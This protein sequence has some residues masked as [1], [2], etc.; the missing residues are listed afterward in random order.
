M[1]RQA[2]EPLR[3]SLEKLK[4]INIPE[5]SPYK[6]ISYSWGEVPGT[7][8]IECDGASLETTRSVHDVLRRL[9]DAEKTKRVWIDGLCINQRDVAE[10]QKVVKRMRDIYASAS[11]VIIWLG[12]SSGD[13]GERFIG[14]Y[15]RWKDSRKLGTPY[16]FISLL[17]R[18]WFTRKWVLQEAVLAKPN[19]L[20]VACGPHTIPWDGEHG[21][22]KFLLDLNM[23]LHVGKVP[24]GGKRI[25]EAIR[26]VRFIDENRATK[27]RPTE[28]SLFHVLLRTRYTDAS[29]MTDYVAAVL[30][31]A[32]DW[33]IDCGLSPRYD[34]SPDD[35]QNTNSDDAIKHRE[36]TN[37]ATWDVTRNRSIRVLA[38]AS[39][40]NKQVGGGLPSWVPD[41]TVKDR[42]EP[43][44]TYTP[45]FLSIWRSTRSSKR[46]LDFNSS[47]DV[48]K[49]HLSVQGNNNPLLEVE[50][51]VIDRV[52]PVT[53]PAPKE[54]SRSRLRIEYP[55]EA[56]AERRAVA[57][58][59][60]Q[61][62]DLLMNNIRNHDDDDLQLSRQ[63]LVRFARAISFRMHSD[64]S[65]EVFHFQHSFFLHHAVAG[66]L[67]QITG[68]S[69][70]AP[71]PEIEKKYMISW[72][73]D[74][75]GQV[76]EPLRRWAVGRRFC[77]TENGRLGFVPADAKAGDKICLIR[78]HGSLYVLR[79]HGDKHHV[80]VGECSF[81]DLYAMPDHEVRALRI[82]RCFLL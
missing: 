71:V 1:S 19:A 74:D 69:Y 53:T 67:E 13:Q 9:R 66:Y 46:L 39:G 70:C 48:G 57:E 51:A 73:S 2:G 82:E 40:P 12:E 42:P 29:N 54:F 80:A 5:T 37:F 47:E 10:K 21:F 27:R 41:W 30:G 14:E 31:L 75:I 52:G 18:R 43:L 11:E 17:R 77:R 56:S 60:R 32:H 15:L 33:N 65:S 64:G 20:T 72:T 55:E 6:A 78:G 68:R 23:G 7:A 45:L 61:C 44:S 4:T 24:E 8:T 49:V 25:Q 22:A 63:D 81:D 62:L 79:E 58:W 35:E 26:T 38:Y 59:F 28:R 3:C 16:D 76:E 34:G 36:F 50:G